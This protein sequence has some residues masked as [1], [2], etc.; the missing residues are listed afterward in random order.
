MENII[1]ISPSMCRSDAEV[2]AMRGTLPK[3]YDYEYLIQDDARVEVSGE[4]V[5]ACL[6]TNC[7]S[8][9]L[10]TESAKLLGTVHGGLSNRG[11]IIYKGSM[12]N[13]ERT[14]ESLSLTK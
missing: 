9:K 7:L 5:L 3:P 12:M 8:T 10:V 13:R 6:V 4:G 1:R 2:E 14:D 11:S